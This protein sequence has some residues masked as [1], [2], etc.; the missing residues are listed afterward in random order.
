MDALLELI[1]TLIAYLLYGSKEE[2][3]KHKRLRTMR[4][5]MG[6]EQAKYVDKRGRRVN[7]RFASK[8]LQ[9]YRVVESLNDLLSIKREASEELLA[10]E[11]LRD[12][13]VLRR[14]P[15]ESREDHLRFGYAQMQEKSGEL[16]GDEEKTWKA[17][18]KDFKSFKERFKEANFLGFNEGMRQVERFASLLDFDFESCLGQFDA[19]QV[20]IGISANPTFSAIAADQV[21]KELLDLYFVMG[22]LEISSQLRTNLEYLLEFNRK[23]SEQ[24]RKILRE[25]L[26]ALAL[27][28]ETEL[29][30]GILKT[31]LC[32][33]DFDPYLEPKCM[34]GGQNYLR[35]FLTKLDERFALNKERLQRNLLDEKLKLKI[36]KV[37]EGEA[38]ASTSPYDQEREKLLV[39]KGFPVFSYRQALRILKTYFT[40][41]FTKGFY[42]SLKKVAQEGYFENRDFKTRYLDTLQRVEGC[43][44]AVEGFLKSLSGRNSITMEDVV[45]ILRKTSISD[46]ERLT[47]KRF[48]KEANHRARQVVEENT[49]Y[50]NDLLNSVGSIME[51][52][53]AKNPRF[54]S[55]LRVIAGERSDDVMRKIEEGSTVLLHLVE[56]MKNYAVIRK[57]KKESNE[58]GDSGSGPAETS[59]KTSSPTPSKE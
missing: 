48:V 44:E 52:Y 36:D 25:N 50:L 47:V 45:K 24:N 46:S 57:E 14:L 4:R 27:I 11:R 16:A 54:V 39:E 29:T 23:E 59:T 13:L 55:N 34:E 32:I 8:L 5:E 9:L 18:E 30:A 22:K 7:P 35:A 20:G 38:L 28:M 49:R 31:M 12:F 19:A 3:I 10:D 37:F 42:G 26:D 41:S 43:G 15:E 21:K 58:S 53:R 17:L 51:D 2:L 33:L 56:I 40:R 1:D 6:F